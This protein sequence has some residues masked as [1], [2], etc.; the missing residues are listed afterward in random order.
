M[1]GE[2]GQKGEE[3]IEVSNSLI[4]KDHFLLTSGSIVI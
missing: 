4:L 1:R 2:R 3:G